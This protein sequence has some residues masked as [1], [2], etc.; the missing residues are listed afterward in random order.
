MSWVSSW[1]AMTWALVATRPSPTTQ[2]GPLLDQPAGAAAHLHHRVARAQGDGVGEDRLVGGRERL[3]RQG[4]DREGVDA[5]QR[6]QELVGRHG[7]EGRRQDAGAL[8]LLADAGGVVAGL[9]EGDGA[10]QPGQGEADRRPHHEPAG[11]VDA[12]DRVAADPAPQRGGQPQQDRLRRPGRP[13]SPCPGRRAAA[14]PTRARPGAGRGR[15]GS[16][17]PRRS[18]GP[19][20]RAPA[21][22]SPGRR[23]GAPRGPPRRSGSSR[24]RSPP[25]RPGGPAPILRRRTASRGSTS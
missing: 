12:P 15:G 25:G 7:P 17:R 19:P 5:R 1:P 20:A 9:V 24:A 13:R 14:T 21:R 6:P 8:D 18:P 4:D 11:L 10:G 2:P 3:D 23:R 22:S 16:R